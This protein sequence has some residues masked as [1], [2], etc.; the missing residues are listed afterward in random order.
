M[1][2]FT[3]KLRVSPTELNW[4]RDQ[5]NELFFLKNKYSSIFNFT[6]QARYVDDYE[7]N[8]FVYKNEETRVD[9]TNYI[10]SAISDEIIELYP[11]EDA[12]DPELDDR[13]K[14]RVQQNN[15]RREELLTELERFKDLRKEY[16]DEIQRYKER[17]LRLGFFIDAFPNFSFDYRR[18]DDETYEVTFANWENSD[19]E[20]IR[21]PLF[22]AVFI[23]K[24][25]KYTSKLE[26]IY[27]KWF[28]LNPDVDEKTA[29]IVKVKF[30][31]LEIWSIEDLVEKAIM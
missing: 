9:R 19:Y 3:A 13:Q 21:N 28:E 11:E 8:V 4:L 2:Q 10:D 24:W 20:Y 26:P 16:I 1:T 6:H 15:E 5:F 22:L 29:G 27:F 30:F 18:V 23:Q 17:Y 14:R 25:M 7:E 31:D 12:E